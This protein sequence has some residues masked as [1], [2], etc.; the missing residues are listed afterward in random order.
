MQQEPEHLG[1]FIILLKDHKVLLGKRKNSYKSGNYGFPGGRLELSESLLDCAKRE[2]LEETGVTA[3][4]LE[5]LGVIREL[6]S[7]YNFIHFGFVCDKYKGNIKV[8]E[9]N[10]CESWEFF[11]P[12]QIP[13]N[14]LPAHKAG[15]KLLKSKLPTYIDLV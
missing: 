10:K 14:T 8:I 5:Y 6:Q 12:D 9:T 4:H 13:P 2:L 7:N 11:S 3:L 15:A 1:A